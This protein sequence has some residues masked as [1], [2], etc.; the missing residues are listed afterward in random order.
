MS[1]GATEPVRPALPWAL[2]EAEPP[3]GDRLTVR[4]ALR[5]RRDDVLIGIDAARR[6]YLLVQIPAGEPGDLTERTSTGIA[7]Q[8]VEMNVGAAHTDR[9]I[10]IACLEAQGYAALDTIAVELIEAL[11]A[12]ASIGRVRLVQSVLAKWRRFWAGVSQGLLSREQQLALFGELWFLVRWL[13]P[14]VGNAKAVKMWRGPTGARNDFESVGIGIEVKTTGRVDG[15]HT[16]NGL[17][18][19]VEPADGVLFL[20]SL[21]VRDEANGTEALPKVVD[22]VRDRLSSDYLALSQF[23]A[24]VYAAGYDDR[25]ASEYAKLTLRIRNESLYRI[26]EGFPRLVPASIAGGLPPGI[27]RVTYDLSL[28]AATPWMVATDADAA[29]IHLTC[30]AE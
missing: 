10:E 20:F 3:T 24:A 13:S 16:V 8:T 29:A 22:E 18:Q 23:D 4:V 7:V 6:R 5:D 27:G 21:L 25:V 12:G 15:L 9:F 17:E 30:F 26:T 14:S 11:D 28:E 19:L 1:A 2:L